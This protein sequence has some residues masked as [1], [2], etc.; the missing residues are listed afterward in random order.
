MIECTMDH[1][2]LSQICRSGQCFRMS[3]EGENRYSVIAGRHYLEL[4]Q[5]GQKCVFDCGEA[6]FENFWKGYFDLETDYG[7]YIG[8]IARG[9]VI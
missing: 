5:A 3:D 7:S 2:D 9:T 6:E 1:F 4:E 8:K